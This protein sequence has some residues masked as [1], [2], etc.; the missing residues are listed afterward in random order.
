MSTS[1]RAERYSLR[2]PVAYDDGE[3]LMTGYV[4]DLSESGLFI[5]TVMPLEAGRTVRITP[6]LPETAGIFELEVAVVRAFEYDPDVL[7]KRP[8]GMGVRF[9]SLSDEEKANLRQL[10]A[11]PTVP[12]RALED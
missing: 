1:E 6:L 11:A 2:F 10:F 5:E 8:P 3:G 12:N 7:M 4:V 9:T